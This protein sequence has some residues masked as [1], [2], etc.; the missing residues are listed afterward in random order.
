MKKNK[1]KYLVFNSTDENKEVSKEYTELS[2]GIKNWDW[3]N[4]VNNLNM[5]K[6]LWRLNST[7]MIICHGISH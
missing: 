1:S 7:P 3:S 4:L 5:T 6:I 2:G